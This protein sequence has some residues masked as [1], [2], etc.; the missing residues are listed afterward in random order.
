MPPPIPTSPASSP[1][2]VPAIAPSRTSHRGLMAAPAGQRQGTP[3]E[4][5]HGRT[6]KSPLSL[7]AS[8]GIARFGPFASLAVSS[9][10]MRG[11][12]PPSW[13][14]GR[15][16][17][18]PDAPGSLPGAPTSPSRG[19][20]ELSCWCSR[21]AA[22]VS[23]LASGPGRQTLQLAPEGHRRVTHRFGSGT[24]GGQEPLPGSANPMAAAY[25][26]VVSG[27]RPFAWV[28]IFGFSITGD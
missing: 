7:T 21:R 26:L 22:F 20:S 2:P 27:A 24:A 15:G 12:E 14:A 3:R 13:T 17:A 28:S 1:A 6:I 23:K 4:V 11:R 25:L 9:Q 10:A 19:T 5:L 16:S 8:R 18:A